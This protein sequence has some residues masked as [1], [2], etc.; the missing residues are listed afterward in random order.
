MRLQNSLFAL[1]A[2]ILGSIITPAVHAQSFPSKPVRI[3]VG[4]P[5]GGTTDTV[6]RAVANEMSKTLGQ[7]VVVENRGGAGGNLAADLVAKSAPDGHTLLVSFTS[8]TINATLYPKLPFDPVGDFTAI[9]MLTTS[10]SLLIGNPSIP[11]N[12]LAELIALLKRSPGKYNF[13]IGAIG[14][15]L[16]MAGEKF[17]LE[18]GT[19]VVNV[20]Y[21]GSAP[22]LQDLLAGQVEL[23][24]VSPAVGGAQL[25]AGK[26]KAFGVT[27]P[28]R[29]TQ[30]PDVAA[31]GEVVKGFESNAWFGLFGPA[32]LPPDVTAKLYEAARAAV[33]ATEVRKRFEAEALEPVGNTPA[34]FTRFVADDIK[35]WEKIV[36][37]SGAKPE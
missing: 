8:H 33:N 36:R 26:V 20:P 35:R 25:K 31:I 27:S 11:A 18:T 13:G 16:H 7:S 30:F 37:F 23:M 3:L 22:A 28:K 19:F 4:A 34:E 10:P 15:S 5:P 2:L 29:L 21:R 32:K 9:T 17:K 14:S 1:I 12:T 6:A 24:F